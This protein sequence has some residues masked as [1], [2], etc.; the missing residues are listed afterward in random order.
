M[1]RRTRQAQLRNR[2]FGIILWIVFGGPLQTATPT[3]FSFRTEAE[4]TRPTDAGASHVISF[5]IE[6]YLAIKIDRYILRIQLSEIFMDEMK[7]IS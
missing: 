1:S 3:V 7:S 6:K 4:V 2:F 5:K